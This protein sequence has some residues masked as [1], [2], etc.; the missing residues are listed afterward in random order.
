MSPE[1]LDL[2]IKW[3]YSNDKSV[4]LGDSSLSHVKELG[5]Y[6]SPLKKEK[7]LVHNRLNFRTKSH[8]FCRSPHK[9][10]LAE[11]HEFCLE[12]SVESLRKYCLPSVDKRIE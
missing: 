7:A 4:D 9:L 3:L 6:I 2:S 8:S 1:F 10:F 12:S 5:V 11:V